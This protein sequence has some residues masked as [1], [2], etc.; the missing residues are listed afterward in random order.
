MVAVRYFPFMGGV[1]THVYE[2]SRRLVQQGFEV[3]VV[4]TNPDGNL[5]IEETREGV[6]IVRVAA[7][8]RQRDFCVS[9]ELYRLIASRRWDI[10]HCQGYHTLFTPLAML[11]AWRAGLPYVVSFHSGGHSSRLRNAVRGLQ[12]RVLRPLLAHATRLVA[13]SNF[14][15]GFFRE[16]LKLSADHFVVIPNGAQLPQLENSGETGPETADAGPLILSV[17]RLERYKGHQRLISALPKVLEK[18]PAARL[19]IVGGGPYE[20]ELQKLVK[21]LGLEDRVAIGAISPTDRQGMAAVVNQAAVVALLSDYEAH[22]VAVMEALALHRPVLVANTS[23]L[24]ELAERRLVRAVPLDS[25]P[26]QIAAA[27]IAQIENP[28]IPAQVELPSW[29]DCATRLAALYQQ[30]LAKATVNSHR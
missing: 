11:A 28:L 9:P 1:E 23:G 6:Q 8:P 27:L 14:E 25:T 15:A 3:T 30:I 4:T 19:R 13:V 2:V 16:K 21:S 26:E 20:P 29:E 10:I 24:R 7:W 17:G 5:P 12:R 18:Y 22:P